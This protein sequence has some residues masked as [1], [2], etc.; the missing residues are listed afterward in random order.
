MVESVKV[1]YWM[2]NER[3]CAIEF[4]WVLVDVPTLISLVLVFLQLAHS[5]FLPWVQQMLACCWW[6]RVELKLAVILC[7]S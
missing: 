2:V 1:Y 7:A 6:R 5:A 4:A 3:V